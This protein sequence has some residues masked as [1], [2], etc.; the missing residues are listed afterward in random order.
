LRP[1]GILPSVSSYPSDAVASAL[2]K[3]VKKIKKQNH[4]GETPTGRKGGTPSPRTT[5]VAIRAPTR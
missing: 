4:A 2:K 5:S 3:K 1:E